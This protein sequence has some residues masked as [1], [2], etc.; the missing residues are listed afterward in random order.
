[1]NGW[2]IFT[3]VFCVLAAIIVF[4]VILKANADNEDKRRENQRARR[5]RGNQNAAPP[6]V[7]PEVPAAPEDQIILRPPAG[8][9]DVP[10]PA[11]IRPFGPFL[12][13]MYIYHP[14]IQVDVW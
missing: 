7:D 8:V 10:P 14:Q 2:V 6:A 1:M 3:I 13:N 4:W 9:P 11:V 5:P 12:T